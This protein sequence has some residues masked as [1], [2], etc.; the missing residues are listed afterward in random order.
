MDIL[1][2][3]FLVCL[4]SCVMIFFVY[5]RGTCIIFHKLQKDRLSR[6]WDDFCYRHL[7]AW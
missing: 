1:E 3:F 7:Y 5:M 4:E 6:P 2:M